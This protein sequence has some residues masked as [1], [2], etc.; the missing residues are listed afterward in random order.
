MNMARCLLREK[1]LPRNFW[2]EAVPTAIHILNRCPTKRLTCK[3]PLEAW[4][5]T[6]PN[7]NHFRVFGSLVFS[8]I[9]DKKVEA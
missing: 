1:N 3:V 5:S 2:G 9:A 4:T 7:V 6:K 8:H